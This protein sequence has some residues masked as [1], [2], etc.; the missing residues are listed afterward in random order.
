MGNC[1]FKGGS[2]PEEDV[3]ISVVQ[4]DLVRCRM[5]ACAPTVK[6]K[7][8]QG[9]QGAMSAFAIEGSGTALG[10]CPIDCDTGYFEVKLGGAASSD[11]I[12]V[13]V[14][15]YN[16]KKNVD[17]T[18]QLDSPN[19]SFPGFCFSSH[20]TVLKAGDVI[21]VHWDQ[22]DLPMLSF[23]VNGVEVRSNILD[24]RPI[25]QNEC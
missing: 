16:A 1:C 4:N 23:T 14:K 24:I 2:A 7:S 13:G 17:L 6:V 8:V 12:K 3:E 10:S 19:E 21:G 5:G 22:T 9:V 20:K 18:G 11:N 25:F 15:R